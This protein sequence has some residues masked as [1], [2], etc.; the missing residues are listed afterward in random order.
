MLKRIVSENRINIWKL[1]KNKYGFSTDSEIKWE[2]ANEDRLILTQPVQ[3]YLNSVIFH[4]S[5]LWKM[6]LCGQIYGDCVRN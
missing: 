5:H 4:I 1:I 6:T 3:F 2:S